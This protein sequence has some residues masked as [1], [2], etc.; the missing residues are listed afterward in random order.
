[1][2][3]KDL[4]KLRTELKEAPNLIDFSSSLVERISSSGDATGTPFYHWRW[5]RKFLADL[6]VWPK[7]TEDI[8][9]IVKLANKYKIPITPRGA[10]SGYYGEG[11]PAD[12]GIVLDIKKFK[13]LTKPDENDY[14]W[15][16]TG[17]C[18][19]EL[20][21]KLNEWDFEVAAYPTSYFASIIGGWIGVGGKMGVGTVKY[22]EFKDQIKTIKVITPTGEILE[23]SDKKE[24]S[25]YFG[26]CGIFGIVSEIQ[27][28][29][30]KKAETEIPLM[31]GFKNL[32]QLLK[33][34]EI[35][36]EETDPFH[37][38]FSDQR[39]EI[40]TSGFQSFPTVLFLIYKDGSS[41]TNSMVAKA[42]EIALAN[43]GRDLG[44]ILAEQT[45]KDFLLHEMKVKLETPVLML[46]QLMLPL[47]KVVELIE[48][49][50]K[51]TDERKLNHCY[52]GLVNRNKVV[53][54]CL[55]TPTDNDYWIHFLSSK[56][57]LHSLVEYCY[58]KIGGRIYSY[59]LQNSIYMV[60]FENDRR[61]KLIELKHSVDPN[62]IVNPL[63]VIESKMRYSRVNI[64]FK[65][66][67][68]WRKIAVKLNIAQEILT[69][70]I[71]RHFGYEG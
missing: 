36:L 47:D 68:F 15:V 19:K 38:R 16:S 55:Y 22:G 32:A 64:M 23:I 66:T 53:R 71:P 45:Y 31:F 13:T 56:A 2:G 43:G 54:L 5:K 8:I 35:V 63:K 39:H 17:Y 41:E 29:V 26:T 3:N 50:E 11:S 18:F 27:L 58:T 34:L 44:E 59:G 30:V 52:Y 10:G 9:F 20:D 69:L 42:K 28:K 49:F 67:N 21:D 6:V 1:M 25:K 24:K 14:C 70:D 62:N 61:K 33:S 65:L 7:S 12:G 4:I 40:R 46:Q 60:K 37:L 51:I 48:R 57:C